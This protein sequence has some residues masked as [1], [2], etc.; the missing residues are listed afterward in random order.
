M[1]TTLTE[2][3]IRYSS[4]KHFRH[5]YIPVY[6]RLFDGLEVKKLL[7]IGIGYHDLMRPFLPP[8]VPFIWGSSLRMWS[9]Y[10]PEADIYACDVHE[11]ALVNEGRIR[12]FYADQSSKADLRELIVKCDGH[13]Q[14]FDVIIDDGSHIH[15]HQVRSLRELLMYVK[16]G[17]GVYVVE[18]VWEDKGQELAKMFDGELIQGHRTGDDNLVV[19]R[20]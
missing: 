16:P 10:W 4:D 15:E 8:D 12:S 2:L 9:E 11:S 17:G 19:I 20:R 3:A 13:K 5:S 6:E 1:K 14:R 7:E 18:D